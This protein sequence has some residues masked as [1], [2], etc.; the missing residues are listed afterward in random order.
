MNN[1]RLM[2]KLLWMLLCVGF[3]ASASAFPKDRLIDSL[4][5]AYAAEG[6]ARRR[7]DILLN[8]KDL[9]DSSE[10]EM[11]YARK[12]F[13]EAFAAGDAFAVGSSLGSLA[14]YYIARPG[15]A[16]SLGK[17]LRAVEPLLEGSSME[18]LP[19]YYRMVD[20]ARRIQVAG[21]EE[22]VRLCQDYVDSVRTSPP[23]TVCDEASQ[24]FL[25]GIAAY[26]LGSAEGRMHMERGLPYWTDE[27]ALLPKMRPTARRNFPAN[28]ITCLISVYG[29]TRDR[30]ALVRTA[31]DYLAMLDAYYL[32]PEVVRRRPYIPKEMSYLVCYYTMCTSPLIDRQRA[33]AYY[34]RYRRFVESSSSRDN[35]LL[36]RHWFYNISVSYYE[37]WGDY[38]NAMVYNDS[39]ILVS[40]PAGMSA[41]LADMYARRANLYERM[42]RYKEAGGAYREVIAVRD[43]LASLQYAQRVGELEVQY[44]LDKVE[45]DRALLLAQ[46]RRNLLWF[47]AVILAIAIVAVVYMWRNLTRIKHLEHNLRIE[48]Q[49]ALESDRLKRDFMGSM[50]HEIRTPL[51]AINGFAELIAEGG[52]SKEES[53]EFAQII[54]DNT[55]LF[56]ALINDMLEV[57]QLDNTVAELPK[58]PVDICQLIRTEIERLPPKD[59]VEYRMDFAGPEIVVPLHRGYVTELIRELLKNAVKFTPKGSVTVACG[60][61]GNGL[62]TLSVTDT[63]C[64]ID[65]ADAERVFERFYKADPFAQGLGLGL[66]L[67]RLIAR[68]S[69]GEIRLDTSYTQGARFVVTLRV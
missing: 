48:S 35:M 47:I 60:C 32:D 12:L 24:L 27:A 59:G 56:T 65:P 19:A 57:S 66:S 63:G 45:R 28:L 37:H 9:T 64:G 25:K 43:S 49:R 51:N 3:T 41:Q 22:S 36:D 53:V 1:T 54:R 21:T 40:R 62:L 39:L 5:G 29:T 4:K 23:H 31:D 26:K 55:Q 7:V 2:T 50:S 44:G 42:G 20:M 17:L 30:D 58:M 46:K 61:A 10:D 6:D 52:L 11:F 15:S 33:G 8:L 68:K 14:S 13:D 67:C 38:A 16:D 18:G 34:D 69:G